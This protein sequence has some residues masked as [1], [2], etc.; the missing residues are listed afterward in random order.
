ML[1]FILVNNSCEKDEL[2]NSSVMQLKAAKK[3]DKELIKA[4]QRWF[5]NNTEQNQFKVLESSDFLKWENAVVNDLDSIVV[6]EVPIKLKEEYSFKVAGNE[7]LNVE[8]RLLIFL[9]NDSYYSLMEYFISEKDLAYLHDTEKLRYSKKENDFEGI[10]VLVDTCDEVVSTEWISKKLK[11]SEVKLKSG[12]SY[13][14]W[15]VWIYE[16]GR[17]EY[18]MPV[19]CVQDSQP[20]GGGG[21]GGGV[22]VPG[23]DASSLP[24]V[25]AKDLENN[26]KAKCI[27][28]KL[29]DGS[30]LNDFIKRY[31]PPVKPFL[32][33]LGELNLTW[34]LGSSTQTLPIG[35][36]ENGVY[37]SV[38]IQLNESNLN[39]MSS[40]NVALSMLH[41]ALHA[42]LIAEVYDEVGSTDFKE[43][44]AYYKNFPLPLDEM[45]ETQM[46]QFYS[47]QMA[48]GLKDFDEN[49][50]II[51][52]ID[53][54]IEAI[55]YSIMDEWGKF[56]KSGMDEYRTLFESSKSCE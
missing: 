24:E 19:Y 29:K 16:S 54:Y 31:F 28:D 41:E 5:D 44:L 23:E 37:N 42:K 25:I 48:Q 13:C 36:P 11:S 50:G 12:G 6:V 47:E 15:L 35:V 2:L 27:Y 9:E 21:G 3:N 52:S 1:T 38:V 33:A 45:Q 20:L 56:Y 32:P 7:K 46:I 34:T 39:A 18:I 17:I 26:P 22:T 4:A 30:I 51:H 40:T 10:I 14:V 43:L 55:K 8:Y 53:F 49:H